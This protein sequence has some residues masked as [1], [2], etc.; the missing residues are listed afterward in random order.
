RAAAPGL[1]LVEAQPGGGEP[2]GRDGVGAGRGDGRLDGVR[3]LSRCQR[4]KGK[5][6]PRGSGTVRGGARQGAERGTAGEAESGDGQ[7]PGEKEAQGGRA[8]SP[9]TPALDGPDRKSVV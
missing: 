1:A 3:L 9:R 5:G 2:A 4:E 6:G 7:G 8:A